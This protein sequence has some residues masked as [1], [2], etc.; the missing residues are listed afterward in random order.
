MDKDIVI[1]CLAHDLPVTAEKLG[2]CIATSHISGS[3]CLSL[4]R[5]QHSTVTTGNFRVGKI[6]QCGGKESKIC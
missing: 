4:M 1:Q 2:C 6:I 3:R 5:H